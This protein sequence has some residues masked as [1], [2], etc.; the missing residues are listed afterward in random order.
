MHTHVECHGPHLKLQHQIHTVS[1]QGTDVI[2]NQ[3][4]DDVYAVGLMRHDAGL[5]GGSGRHG[6]QAPQNCGAPEAH[7]LPCPACSAHPHLHTP[8]RL[9]LVLM[10]TYLVLVAG[11]LTV[12]SEGLQGLDDKAHVVLIDVKP[13]QPQATGGAAAH[14]VQELQCLT[15]Q[16]VVGLVVLGAQEVLQ[17]TEGWTWHRS[18]R[19]AEACTD[20]ERR[21]A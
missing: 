3:G 19:E 4:C 10:A 11:A 5:A 13:Q 20:H 18:R 16:V 9:L 17:S 1:A 2:K 8:L 7:R 15:H 14:D 21:R 6:A 12:L